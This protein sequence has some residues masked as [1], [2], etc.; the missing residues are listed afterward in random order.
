MQKTWANHSDTILNER[1]AHFVWLHLYGE[2]THR[3]MKLGSGDAGGAV[4][5]RGMGGVLGDWPCLAP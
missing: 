2:Q 1:K 5:G 3:G 4:I